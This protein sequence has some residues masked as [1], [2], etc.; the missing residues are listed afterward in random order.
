ML[1]VGES[2]NPNAIFH[3]IQIPNCIC[4]LTYISWSAKAI[5]GRLA[6]YYG[7]DGKVYP[8]QEVLSEELGLSKITIIRSLKELEDYSFIKIT[9]PT[10]EEKLKHFN[11]SYEF[12]WHECFVKDSIAR[13]RKDTLGSIKK[14]TPYI[15][16]SNKKAS[17]SL[18]N[19]SKEELRESE[20]VLTEVNTLSLPIKNNPIVIRRREKS[21]S[22]IEKIKTLSSSA[23]SPRPLPPK[24]QKPPLQVTSTVREVFDF[25]L[26]QNLRLPSPETKS[27]N[28]CIKM[29]N[30]LLNGRLFNQKYSIEEI[31]TSIMNFS[32]AALDPDFE[33]N[34]LSYKK[35]LAKKNIGEFIYN[36]FNSNGNS[37]LFKNYLLQPP[38]PIKSKQ[39]ITTEH[40]V[41]SNKL[42]SFYVEEVLGGIKVELSVRDEN[43]F[44]IAANRI[45]EFYENNHS[46]FN[47]YMSINPPLMAQWLWESIKV[48]CGDDISKITPGWFYSDTTFNRR[49]PAYL[50]RQAILEEKGSKVFN[51]YDYNK[52]SLSEKEKR[53]QAIERG[54]VVLDI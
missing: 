22:S 17:L 4:K 41:L 39:V 6:Q 25:W 38:R 45:M 53:E 11:N 29:V 12:L 1:K 13:Y 40:P 26:E 48:D 24:K 7:H 28:N 9:K 3:G 43:C 5:Y 44:R 33:P 8:K 51:M 37:S 15:I 36:S 54:D 49:F 30:R 50:F 21:I 23:L 47:S 42:R 34:D 35:T 27:Y 52:Q 14:D 10:G 32:F 46:Q 18:N 31:K 19:S 2:F 20:V 16:E